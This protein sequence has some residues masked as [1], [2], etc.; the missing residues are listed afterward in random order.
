M[1]RSTAPGAVLKEH[2]LY[3]KSDPTS[4]HRWEANQFRLILHTAAYWL[5]L[6]VRDAGPKKSQWRRAT[7][8]SIRNTVLKIAA[9]SAQMK[10]RIRVS[11]PTVTPNIGVI[12]TMLGKLA[13]QVL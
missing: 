3:L 2:K 6:R 11:L 4:Y 7:F 12:N 1:R 9:R 13:A 5:M 10:T 8:E